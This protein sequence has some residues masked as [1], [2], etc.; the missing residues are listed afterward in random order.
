MEM[1]R[2]R[3]NSESPRN[4]QSPRSSVRGW[5]TAGGIAALSAVAGYGTWAATR[6]KGRLSGFRSTEGE[7]QYLRA[8]QDVLEEWPAAYEEIAVET[9]FGSTHVLVSGD[10]EAPPLVLLHATGTS[11]TGWLANVGPLSAR[12]RVFAVDIV[13]EAGKSHQSKLLRGRK[14]CVQW[15][16]SVLDGLGLER[17]S[18]VGWS[19]GGWAALAFTIDRP[20]RVDKTVLLAP[21]GSLAPYSRSIL[22]F[23]KVGPYLPWGPPG[24]L[25]LRMMAPGY[26][27][28]ERFA[29]QFILGGRYFKPADPRVSVFPRPFTTKELSS[30]QVPVLL[31][32]G[33]RESAFDPRIAVSQARNFIPGAQT[34]LV[35]GVGHMIA[36]EAQAVVNH[37]ILGFLQDL[38]LEG[39]ARTE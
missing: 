23:L 19:F 36:M 35:P 14:D 12:C 31:M 8:Y 6:R 33:D 39:L 1:P 15:L 37:A 7:Q 2:T 30:I 26:R 9:L 13:G 11:S 21:F 22:A 5:G 4:R 28:D 24:G 17:P 3:A 27:F 25:A 10:T 32:V 18:L 34:H 38:P 20:E 29:K 16:S